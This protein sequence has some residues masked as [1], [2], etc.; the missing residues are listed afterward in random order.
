MRMGGIIALVSLGNEVSFCLLC[1]CS[2]DC[3]LLLNCLLIFY[4]MLSNWMIIV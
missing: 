4:W 1:S 2:R 3:A